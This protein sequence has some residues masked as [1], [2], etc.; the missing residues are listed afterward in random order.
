MSP[1]TS[2][3]KCLVVTGES[4]VLSP[5]MRARVV[6]QTV[7]VAQASG[8]FAEVATIELPTRGGGELATRVGT[9]LA[10]GGALDGVA[11]IEAGLALLRP[12]TWVSAFERLRAADAQAVVSVHAPAGA[13]ALADGY[14]PF[15]DDRA[16]DAAPLGLPHGGLLV[17]RREAWSGAIDADAHTTETLS[18]AWPEALDVLHTPG[19]DDAAAAWLLARYAHRLAGP[20]IKLVVFDIDGVMTDAGFYYDEHKQAMKKFSTRDGQGLVILR[21]LGVELGI[22]TGERTGFA[23]VRARGLQIKRLAAGT[24]DKLP[25]LEAWRAEMGLEWDQI[26]YMGDDLPDLPC[27]RRVGVA[28]CPADAEP[29]VQAVAR[30]IST[31]AGGHGAVRDFIRHLIVSGRIETA[32]APDKVRVYLANMLGGDV[33]RAGDWGAAAPV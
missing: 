27:L 20:P 16:V 8:C 29:E 14:P 30:F 12:A 17:A 2:R 28:A 3:W 4:G 31:R 1:N 21:D 22:I 24:L 15:A 25:V 7:G 6:R 33:E 19:V 23:E 26:A 18:L 32:N 11:V 5:P 10:A 13:P 9:E